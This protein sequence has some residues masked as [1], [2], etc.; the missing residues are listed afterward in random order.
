MDVTAAVT[1]SIECRED[2]F[3]EITESKLLSPQTKHKRRILNRQK[4]SQGSFTFKTKLVK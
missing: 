3:Q 4:L 1:V 2:G